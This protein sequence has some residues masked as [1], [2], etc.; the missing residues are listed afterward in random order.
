M[1]ELV[2]MKNLIKQLNY[3]TKLYNQG[4]PEISDKEYDELYFKLE[5]LEKETNL[6]YPNSPTQNIYFETVSA[7]KKMT[8]NH[9]MLSLGKTKNVK[10]L[11]TFINKADFKDSQGWVGMFKMDGL[12]CSLHYINGELVSAETRGNGIEGE[13]IT[14]NAFVINN[15]PKKIFYTEELIVDGEIICDYETFKEFKGEYKNPRNF[16]AG[17]IR[18]LSS[19]EVASRH[20]SFVAWDLIRGY[21]DIDFFFWRLEKLDELGFNTVPRVGDAETIE[22]AIKILDKMREEHPYSLYPIDGYVFRFESQKY[23][24]SCGRT[25][26]HFSGAL[27]YKFYDEEY[28]TTLLDIELSMGRT[29]VLTPVAI[30][31]PVDCGDSVIERASLHNISVMLELFGGKSPR[32]GQQIYVAKMNMIIP[33]VVR[34]IS[35]TG[36]EKIFFN[37]QVVTCPV[38]GENL[39]IKKSD[40]G[41]LNYVCENP[42][43]EGKL[44][45]RLDHYL[46]IKGLNIKGISKMTL[47]KLIEWNWINSI[48]DIYNLKEHRDEWI[49]KPGFGVASVDKVLSAI[50]ENSKHVSLINFISALGIPLVGK[51]VAK[52]ITKYYSTWSEFMEAIGGDW[53]EFD[54]FGDIMSKEINNFDYTEANEIVDTYLTFEEIKEEIRNDKLAGISFCVTGKLK[55]FKKRDDLKADIESKG[56]KMV[57]SVT[58]KT[59]YLVTNT[60]NNGTAKNVQAQKLGI[61]IITEEEYLKL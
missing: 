32:R 28:A 38:C 52:Q 4:T 39:I 41:V 5:E 44:I 23:Y 26:H 11:E 10:E 54:G 2:E 61:P 25:E 1:N 45:N 51:A 43:C 36:D 48:K 42:T 18:Q 29:G 53:S 17:S 49:K 31:E 27:A 16:A 20:L 30:F 57:S 19:A 6:I 3:H 59:T 55:I 60:P 12:T 21:D 22:D 33:Q 13:D 35:N 15:I 7:L 46:G 56:G 9:P 40:S 14:H 58:S 50:E 34:A 8:H 47:N 24:E 37:N